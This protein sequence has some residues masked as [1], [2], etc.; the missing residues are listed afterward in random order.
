MVIKLNIKK[1]E[2]GSSV[3]HQ[4]FSE[5]YMYYFQ[6]DKCIV[7]PPHSDKSQKS[8]VDFINEE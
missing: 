7:V 2:E 1:I 5:N 3:P 6:D 8:T 4:D